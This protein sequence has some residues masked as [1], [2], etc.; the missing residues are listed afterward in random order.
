MSVSGQSLAWTESVLCE[1]DLRKHLHGLRE[2]VLNPKAIVTP[3]AL[4]LLNQKKIQIRRAA[5]I[6]KEAATGSWGYAEATPSPLVSA[7][8]KALASEGVRMHAL[9]PLQGTVESWVRAVAGNERS[10]VFCADP[11]LVCCL[12]NKIGGLRAA[13]VSTP[14]QV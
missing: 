2:I 13:A 7:A 12:A 10:I 3:L 1:E 8:V 4:D 6:V 5:P 9:G 14:A 11:A